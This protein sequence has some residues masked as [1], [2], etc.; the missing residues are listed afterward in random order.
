MKTDGRFV[1][2]YILLTLN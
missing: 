2:A 1:L